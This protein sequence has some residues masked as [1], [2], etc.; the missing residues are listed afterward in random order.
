VIWFLTLIKFH[1]LKFSDFSSP[2]FY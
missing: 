2:K 1:F